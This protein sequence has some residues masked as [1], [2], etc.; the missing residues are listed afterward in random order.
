MAQAI[1]NFRH[2]QPALKTP[3]KIKMLDR[4]SDTVVHPI[5]LLRSSPCNSIHQDQA[6]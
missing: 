1:N 5:S 4:D 6:T 3:L 2:A